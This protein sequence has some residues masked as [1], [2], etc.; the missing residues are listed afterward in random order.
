MNEGDLLNRNAFLRQFSPQL[1]VHIKGSVLLRNG[2]VA[3]DQLR[4]PLIPTVGPFLI[5]VIR[6]GAYLTAFVIG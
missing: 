1:V 2:K 6:A 5:D 3:K 4:E